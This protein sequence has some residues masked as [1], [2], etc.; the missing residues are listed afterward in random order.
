MLR[1]NGELIPAVAVGTKMGNVFVLHRETGQPLFGVEER[2]V[3]SSDVPGEVASRTQ[4]HPAELPPL[5]PQRLSAADAFGLNTGDRE[6]CADQ[7]S[8]ARNEGMFT[9][10]EREGNPG[11]SV[12]CGAVQWGGRLSTERQWI[13]ADDAAIPGGMIPRSGLR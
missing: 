5:V 1:K 2:S 9:P 3:P 7:I 4:P 12:E 10:P 13:C 6:W 8:N 11:V